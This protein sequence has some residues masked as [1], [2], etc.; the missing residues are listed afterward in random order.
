M[1]AEQWGFAIALLAVAFL[2]YGFA[3]AI[4][5]ILSAITARVAKP[6]SNG[7]KSAAV[8]VIWTWCLMAI[9]IIATLQYQLATWLMLLYIPANLLAT[10]AGACFGN[11]EEQ[12]D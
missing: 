9:L 1:S 8:W 12:E 2:S 6:T 4:W 5:S 11:S 7:L 3:I 10:V